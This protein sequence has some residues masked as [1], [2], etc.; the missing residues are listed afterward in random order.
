M[1]ILIVGSNGGSFRKLN[2]QISQTIE[3]LRLICNSLNQSKKQWWLLHNMLHAII[4]TK[5]S[6]MM[7]RK[8]KDQ[9][10]LPF[11][12]WQMRNKDIEEEEDDELIDLQ[13]NG[14]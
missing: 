10:D 4:E 7:E 2:V 1:P 14:D 9:V 8:F 5:S 3:S 13:V 12:G 11:N 6:K